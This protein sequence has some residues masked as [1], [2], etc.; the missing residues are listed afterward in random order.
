MRNRKKNIVRIFILLLDIIISNNF[1][2]LLSKLIKLIRMVSRFS[3]QL[4]NKIQRNLIC[5]MMQAKLINFKL[6]NLIS[7]IIRLSM[8]R[9]INIIVINQVKIT[10]KMLLCLI[11]KTI[12]FSMSLVLEIT[13]IKL[14]HKC[15]KIINIILKYLYKIEVLLYVTSNH[16]DISINLKLDC[17][18]LRNNNQLFNKLHFKHF[19]ALISKFLRI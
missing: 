3:F 15:N 16:S 10:Q 1:H 7:R 5:F 6:I 12:L 17:L 11:I 19:K 14:I 2:S 9:I 18:V 8:I 4:I 13:A